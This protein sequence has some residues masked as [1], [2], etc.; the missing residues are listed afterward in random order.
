[1]VR[2]TI[3]TAGPEERENLLQILLDSFG[4][5]HSSEDARR[6]LF[7]GSFNPQGCFF[8]EE[9]ASAVGCVAVTNLPHE[10]WYVIRYLAVKNA[11]SRSD[12][13]KTLVRQAIQYAKSRKASF[14]R[15]TTPAVQPYVD[16]YKALGFEPVRRD[17]R[18]IWDLETNTKS[19][20][21]SVELKDVTKDTLEKAADIFIESI[22]PYWNWR[23]EKQGG[24]AAVRESFLKS[25]MK[26]ERWKIALRDSNPVGLAGQIPDYYKLGK[27]RFRGAYVLPEH[28]G[29][30]VG[31]AVMQQA[32]NWARDL[33]QKKM[34]IYTFSYLD[35]LAPGAVLYLKSGGMIDSEY[36]QLQKTDRLT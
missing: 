26:H 29:K 3:R 23:T 20:D 18:I 27:A 7:S 14:L 12:V 13:A 30:G 22:T 33:G 34:V 17:F 21:D 6:E 25:F 8:A 5:F 11:I 10:G 4:H 35:S 9:N 1:M 15:A 32:L 19:L 31:S 36:I 28:R 2:V 24:R 16:I